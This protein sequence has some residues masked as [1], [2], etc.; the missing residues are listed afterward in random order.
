LGLAACGSDRDGK[1]PSPHPASAVGP[2]ISV[3]Q[4]IRAHSAEPLLVN[5]TLF[6]QKGQVLLC[7]AV[8]ES[9][10][11]QCVG[12]RLVVNGFDPAKV[13][14]LKSA[15]DVSWK[16]EPVQLLGVVADGTIS[17]SENAQA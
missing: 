3:E 2:G 9:Y 16:D 1:A 10:P 8:A 6:V 4:A 15:G 14:G 13:G 7:G 5:G 11:P 17:V 12:D